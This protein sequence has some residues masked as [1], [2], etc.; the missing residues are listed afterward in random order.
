MKKI[1]QK[2][3]N[4]LTELGV[5]QHLKGYQYLT[6]AITEAAGAEEV[7]NVKVKDLYRQIAKLYGTTVS[8]VEKAIQQAIYA[9]WDLGD[10]EFLSMFLGC[11]S[12]TEIRPTNSEFIIFFADKVQLELLCEETED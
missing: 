11:G 2:A 3:K 1:Q 5:P 7:L 9:T 12:D 10:R 4:M 6:E 8:F